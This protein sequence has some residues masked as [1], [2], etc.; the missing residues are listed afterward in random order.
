MMTAISDILIYAAL[1]SGNNEYRY[2][3]RDPQTNVNSISIFVAPWGDTIHRVGS[4]FERKQCIPSYI[5]SLSST[6]ARLQKVKHIHTNES[7]QMIAAFPLFFIFR[8]ASRQI[9][10]NVIVF[11]PVHIILSK[12]MFNR[13]IHQ[14]KINRSQSFHGLPHEVLLWIQT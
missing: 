2:R 12:I 7:S 3:L 14:I 10:W 1:F 8:K 4:V 9:K 6:T 13:Y 11:S 5:A